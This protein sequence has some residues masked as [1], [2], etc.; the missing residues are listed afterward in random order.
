MEHYKG[1]DND[2]AI[3]SSNY[4]NTLG[5]HGMWDFTLYKIFNY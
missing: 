2:N 3:N 4:N 1:Y 5:I